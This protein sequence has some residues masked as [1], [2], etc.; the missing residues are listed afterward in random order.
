MILN[1]YFPLAGLQQLR[2]LVADDRRSRAGV[3]GQIAVVSVIG[4]AWATSEGSLA[5]KLIQVNLELYQTN[6]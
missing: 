4:I 3:L 5:G 1:L 2:P 6:M